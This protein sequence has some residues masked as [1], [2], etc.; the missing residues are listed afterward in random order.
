MS[1]YQ[2]N[3]L[4]QAQEYWERGHSLPITLFARLAGEGM[5]VETLEAK[6]RKEQ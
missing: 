2:I 4:E 1:M 3:L 6:H 5:D